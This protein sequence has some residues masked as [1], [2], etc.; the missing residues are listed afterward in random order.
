MKPSHFPI[1][2]IIFALA[3]D[4]SQLEKATR[5]EKRFHC[6][7]NP[8]TFLNRELKFSKLDRSPPSDHGIKR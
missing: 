1:I 2:E 4:C 5:T 3:G 6:E 8:W 7:S